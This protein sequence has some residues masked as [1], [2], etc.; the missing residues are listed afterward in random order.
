MMSK[1]FRF[2]SN[3][4]GM[5]L[6]ANELALGDNEAEE[7]VN[8][9]PTQNGSWTTQNL[10]YV[11][12][13][14]SPLATG[15]PVHSMVT[16][17]TETGSSFLLAAAG[18]KLY[19][20][21]PASGSATVINDALTPN[22]RI[23]FV[24]FQGV[25]IGC[26]GS[27]VPF[28]WSGTGDLE[29][30]AGWPPAISGVAPG[31]PAIAEIFANRLVLS[32]DDS[33][34]S[35]VYLSALEN[36]ENFTPTSGPASAGAIQVS[37]GDG[38]KITGLKT[39]YLPVDSTEILVIFKEKSTYILSGNDADDFTLH[40]VSSEFGAV[41]PRSIVV[42]GNTLMFL[43]Q[44]G[45][46]TLSTATVQGNITAGFLS[47]KVQPVFNQLNRNQIKYSFALHLRDRQEVWWV[48]PPQ[49]AN[50]NQL[51]MVHH[52]GLASDG[53]A[54]S[55]RTGLSL[56]SG[57]IYNGKFYTGNYTG[58]VQQQFRGNRYGSTAISWRYR[59]P[60]Y[61]LDSPRLRKR[62]QDVEIYLKQ[63]SPQDLTVKTAW[64]AK[65]GSQAQDTYT[66][67]VTPDASSAVYQ[68]ATFGEDYYG[69]AG[70]SICPLIP[71][72]SG[73]RFQLEFSG[74]ADNQPVE[75]QGWTITATYGGL[76]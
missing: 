43:S 25:L 54:W 6:Q 68:Q 47:S 12:L 56:A 32:G 65:R 76:R 45:I 33:N 50:Q 31:K 63:L 30:L 14:A 18:D 41:G 38:Q 55:K 37:P 3:T 17:K 15:S 39:L 5:N 24:T 7:I 40:Q 62:I 74:N 70:L 42:V 21:N 29:T 48:V 46:T 11:A 34:P 73:K 51:V 60:F 2:F 72:G 26:N 13:N 28:K 71:N 64:D 35:V 23:Q 22:A 75:L 27:E 59:T 49:G 36:P 67:S 52:Y 4:G 8:L 10:G 58:G 16:Y 53:N 69:I 1:T 9:Q 57:V 66:L 61:E 19:T 44:E 20:F